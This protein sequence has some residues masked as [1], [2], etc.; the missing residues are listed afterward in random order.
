MSVIGR[1]CAVTMTMMLVVIMQWQ[2]KLVR[3]KS[4]N[5][6]DSSASESA[7]TG[8]VDKRGDE[9]EAKWTPITGSVHKFIII[10]IISFTAC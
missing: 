7:G 4:L 1:K 9:S 2:L 6:A 3:T 10:I 8:H 5:K